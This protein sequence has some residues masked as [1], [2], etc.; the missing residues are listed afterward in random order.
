MQPKF[1]EG[2]ISGK[3]LTKKATLNT[4][5]KAKYSEMMKDY[6]IENDREEKDL[7]E[8]FK[9]LQHLPGFEKMLDEF[10]QQ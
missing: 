7:F 3:P 9:K 5:L 4:S 6:D 10:E 8:R 2:L 1:Q